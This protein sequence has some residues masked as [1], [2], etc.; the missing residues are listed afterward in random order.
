MNFLDTKSGAV[1]TIG[2]ILGVGFVAFSGRIGRAINPTSR[3]NIFY[4]GTNDVGSILTQNDDFDLGSW[5]YD[6]V[7]SPTKMALEPQYLHIAYFNDDWYLLGGVREILE[8]N[9]K[10]DL[11]GMFNSNNQLKVEYRG[12]VRTG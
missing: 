1:V 12:L 2:L 9:Y 11:D 6:Q 7:N 3:D 5:I 4:Q 10:S 8:D